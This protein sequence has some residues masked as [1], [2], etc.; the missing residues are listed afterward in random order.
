MAGIGGGAPGAATPDVKNITIGPATIVLVSASTYLTLGYTRGESTFRIERDFAEVD[1]INQLVSP[2]KRVKI[3]ER[4]FFEAEIVELNLEMLKYVMD[5]SA[6]LASQA[7][8]AGDDPWAGD[9]TWRQ[10]FGGD[11]AITEYEVHAYT[12]A[13]EG[14]VRRYILWKAHF[15]GN[16]EEM[17]NKGSE[18]GTPVTFGAIADMTKTKGAQLLRIEDNPSRSFTL[19]ADPTSSYPYCEGWLDTPMIVRPEVTAPQ[20]RK[21]IEKNLKGRKSQAGKRR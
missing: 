9:T 16:V 21:T 5:S 12:M 18:S 15:I 20:I 17:F 6:A 7:I 1:D 14:K 13:P 11:E 8:P 10:D 4:A 2:V 3:A 19:D